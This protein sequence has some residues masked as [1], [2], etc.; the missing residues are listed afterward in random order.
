MTEVVIAV[1]TAIIIKRKKKIMTVV[2]I[3]NNIQSC[4]SN[5]HDLNK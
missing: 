5:S 4:N 2:R 1:G 3:Q